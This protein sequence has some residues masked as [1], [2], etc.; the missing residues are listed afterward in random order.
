MIINGRKASVPHTVTAKSILDARGRSTCGSVYLPRPMILL[1][2]TQ[3]G[4]VG[5]HSV[6]SSCSS[7]QICCHVQ[8]ILQQSYQKHQVS[9]W[10]LSHNALHQGIKWPEGGGRAFCYS[11]CSM[12]LQVHNCASFNCSRLDET[13][14]DIAWSTMLIH[15]A[16]RTCKSIAT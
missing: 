3:K 13:E 10:P 14:K 16:I 2:N 9:F 4:E 5:G 15:H 7:S 12:F 6:L 1:K 8:E 11:V